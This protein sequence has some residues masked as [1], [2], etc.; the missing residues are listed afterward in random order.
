MHA[1]AKMLAK[2]QTNTAA[3]VAFARKILELI[4]SSVQVA[5]DFA[6][7]YKNDRYELLNNIGVGIR[8]LQLQI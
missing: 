6:I 3:L 8:Y 1:L 5:N 2:L 4:L 7:R